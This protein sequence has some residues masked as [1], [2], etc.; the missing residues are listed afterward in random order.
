MT[1]IIFGASS[2]LGKDLCYEFVKNK[3]KLIIVSRDKRDL[4]NLK[5]NIKTMYKTNIKF[6]VFD[7]SKN[8][9]IDSII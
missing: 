9:K 5:N 3:K 1:F 7:F 8:I 2:G 6:L 4:I